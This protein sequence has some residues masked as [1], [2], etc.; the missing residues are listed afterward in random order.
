MALTAPNLTPLVPVTMTNWCRARFEQDKKGQPMADLIDGKT[1]H[2]HSL[3]SP[4]A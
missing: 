1:I 2:T 4:P 3:G